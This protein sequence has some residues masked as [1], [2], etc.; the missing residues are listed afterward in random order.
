MKYPLPHEAKLRPI[1]TFFFTEDGKIKSAIQFLVV[2]KSLS[3]VA[4]DNQMFE[5]C[6]HNSKVVTFTGKKKA[7][8]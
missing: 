4:F 3:S 6:K 5:N 7:K 2:A 1:L 8:N